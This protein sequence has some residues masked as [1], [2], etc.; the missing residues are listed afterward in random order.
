MKPTKTISHLRSHLFDQLE[1]IAQS[2][3]KEELEQELKKAES[4]VQI[5]DA[6]LRTAE[7]EARIIKN[8]TTLHSA[9]IPDV[10]QEVKLK[11]IERDGEPYKFIDEFAK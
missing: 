6:L 3:S 2:N 11:Q 8:V 10:L 5:S 4:V 7:A 1:R 9:F